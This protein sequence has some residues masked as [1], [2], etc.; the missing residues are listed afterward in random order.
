[1]ALIMDN[2]AIYDRF[3]LSCFPSSNHVYIDITTD[4]LKRAC[5]TTLFAMDDINIDTTTFHH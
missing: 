1:M 4:I 2:Y 5:S 3:S